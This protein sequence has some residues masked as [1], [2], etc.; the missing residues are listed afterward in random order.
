[1]WA[2]SGSNLGQI[3]PNIWT[4][5]Q[6]GWFTELT[7]VFTSLRKKSGAKIHPWSHFMV[8]NSAP[9]VALF[10][11]HFQRWSCFRLKKGQKSGT[12]FQ[13]GS[14][15]ELFWLHL[16][17]SAGYVSIHNRVFQLFPRIVHVP[18]KFRG[19]VEFLY[20]VTLESRSG[21]TKKNF[22]EQLEHSINNNNK[23]M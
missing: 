8:R 11:C 17:L 14:R 13:N 9:H 7:K 2:M 3:F 20:Q 4:A 15:V 22:A 1:M 16:F 10:W 12:V 21:T 5:P 19:L 6:W 23:N 18:R